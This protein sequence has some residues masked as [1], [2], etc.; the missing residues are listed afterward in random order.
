MLDGPFSIY[1]LLLTKEKIFILYESV[2]VSLTDRLSYYLV[3]GTG[4]FYI[5]LFI[6]PKSI[7]I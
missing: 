3:T 2:D 4:H 7:K 6:L 5:P 1:Q